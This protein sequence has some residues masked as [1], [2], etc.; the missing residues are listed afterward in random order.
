MRGDTPMLSPSLRILSHGS[1]RRI[2]CAT[3]HCI[4]MLIYYCSRVREIVFF[5]VGIIGE[6]LGKVYIESKERPRFIIEKTLIK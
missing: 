2:V 4:L 6:Y 3:F 5:C 1:F